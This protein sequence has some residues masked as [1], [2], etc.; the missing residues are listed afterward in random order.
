[1][2]SSLDYITKKSEIQAE[3]CVCISENFFIIQLLTMVVRDKSP[4]LL[5]SSYATVINKNN[6]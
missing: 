6:N 1:M 5:P 3:N 2:T 4:P